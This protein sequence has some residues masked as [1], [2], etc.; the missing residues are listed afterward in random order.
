MIE[1][2]YAVLKAWEFD[3]SKRDNIDR[4]RRENYVK[5]K[6]AAW[7]DDVAWVLNRRFE[8]DTRD[9]PLALLAKKGLSLEEWKPVLLWHITRDEFLV[10]DFLVG[11]LY[12]AYLG[13]VDCF[14]TSD[15]VPY[16][17]SLKNRGAARKEPWAAETTAR[18]AAAILKLAAEFGLLHGSIVKKF[19]KYR[20]PERSFMHLLY[21]M[22]D[23]QWSLNTII[24]SA[25]WRM[26]MMQRLDVEREI[27]RLRDNGKIGFDTRNDTAELV[28]PYSCALEYA[29]NCPLASETCP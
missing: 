10:R 12:E 23:A 7:L 6:N 4:L 18:V 24:S 19:A 27:I 14:R 1:E 2:T 9:R 29:Q 11:W 26:Y 15:I 21:A 28:L 20:L 8:P 3:R 13:G 16:L 22:K 17:E 25:D 5:A